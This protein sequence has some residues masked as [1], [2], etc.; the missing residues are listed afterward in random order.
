LSSK[1]PDLNILLT[2]FIEWCSKWSK[3]AEK[4]IQIPCFKGFILTIRAIL[5]TYEK[6]ANEYEGFEL[7]TGLCNQDS[8]EHLFSKLRQRGGFNPNP[9]ARMVRLSLRHILSTGYI[10]TSDKGNV[11]CPESETLINQPSHLIKTVEK[12]MNISNSN[13]EHND[14]ESELF[15]EDAKFLEEFVDVEDIESP[16]SGYD[17]NAIAYFARFVARRSIIKSNCKNCRNAM[18]K[19]PMSNG[20]KISEANY[21]LY[22]YHQNTV[23][24]I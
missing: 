16:L 4:V 22:K 12:C 6:L 1:N 14:T 5:M 18:M 11:Q 8:V 23:N 2:D 21:Y 19:T 17:E 3:S 24:G 7:A 15:T 20:D 10:Q 13:T 9:T